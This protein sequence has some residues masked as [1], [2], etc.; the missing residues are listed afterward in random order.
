MT[1]LRFRYTKLGKIRFIGHRDLARLWERAL[2]RSGLPVA[3]TEGFSPRPKVHF[4]L[5]LSTG[6]ESLGEYIDVDLIDADASAPVAYEADM[7]SACLDSFLPVGVDVQAAAPIGRQPSL[8]AAVASCSW[9]IHLDEVSPSAIADSVEQFLGSNEVIIERTRDE[10]V[11]EINVRPSVESLTVVGPCLLPG[12]EA[13]TSLNLDLATAPPGLKVMELIGLL[14]P[15][16]TAHRVCRTHQWIEGA[17]SRQE[18]LSV[19]TAP[20][21]AGRQAS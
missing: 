15:T 17:G 13:G 7:L 19:T 12:W 2:R 8:Q 21:L 1:R 11:T 10:R 6:F 18:P 20:A 9:I 5:A 4:G 16:A 3:S 14:A